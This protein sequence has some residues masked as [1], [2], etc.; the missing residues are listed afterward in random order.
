LRVFL[1]VDGRVT[2]CSA[3]DA[4]T[5][6]SLFEQLA[7]FLRYNFVIS[8]N[9]PFLLLRLVLVSADGSRGIE[10]TIRLIG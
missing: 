8:R 3:V 4:S 7:K 1:Q 10:A 5:F 2:K 9:A 6:G